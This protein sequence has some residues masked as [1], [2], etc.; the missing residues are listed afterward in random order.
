MKEKVLI[1][2][3]FEKRT[4]SKVV[5]TNRKL[6]GYTDRSFHAKYNYERKGL[7]SNLNIERITKGAILTDLTNEKKVTETLHSQGTKK[8]KRYH[9]TI[10]KILG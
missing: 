10:N 8:I 7:L 3:E 2:Y 9:I 1:V 6:F 5:Q 4:P